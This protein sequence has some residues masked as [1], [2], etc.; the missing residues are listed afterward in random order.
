MWDYFNRY[1]ENGPSC[2]HTGTYSLTGR[3]IYSNDLQLL[4]SCGQKPTIDPSQA[5]DRRLLW[6]DCVLVV[7]AL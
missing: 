1:L 5:V 3:C 2:F 7:V 6:F 4:L